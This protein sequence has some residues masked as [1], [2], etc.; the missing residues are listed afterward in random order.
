MHGRIYQSRSV[1]KTSMKP[2][3]SCRISSWINQ[4][5]INLIDIK[6]NN[7]K[8]ET[9]LLLNNGKESLP[10][11]FKL[12]NSLENKIK[13]KEKIVN[14][15]Y[16]I[17]PTGRFSVDLEFVFPSYIQP[18]SYIVI[19]KIRID[20]LGEFDGF[21]YCIDVKGT[22]NVYMNNDYKS[23]IKQVKKN[24]NDLNM[25]TQNMGKQNIPR[26]TD[27]TTVKNKYNFHQVNNQ[28]KNKVQSFLNSN[29]SSSF[30]E[31]D[32]EKKNIAEKEEKDKQKNVINQLNEEKEKQTDVINRLKEKNNMLVQQNEKLESEKKMIEQQYNDLNKKYNQIKT[33]LINI[34]TF[35]NLANE[36]RIIDAA[37]LEDNF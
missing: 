3:Y 21:A 26:R 7:V 4:M 27:N 29:Q 8:K 24:T 1:E 34:D 37:C 31:F 17:P 25:R 32:Y 33:N 18:D 15:H 5:E 2:L 28:G 10:K 23:R 20:K 36:K 6:K 13:F 16:E 12:V 35:N 9:I 30:N 22:K 19:G 11:V 14:N